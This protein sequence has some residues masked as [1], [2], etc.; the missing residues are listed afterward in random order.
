[1][2]FL[3]IKEMTLLISVIII[4]LIIVEA[5]L[6]P[7]SQFAIIPR[8]DVGEYESKS[9]EHFVIDNKIGWKMKENVSFSWTSSEWKS[10]NHANSQGFRSPE[11]ILN[12]ARKKIVLIGDS[13]GFGQFVNYEETFGAIIDKQNPGFVVY[14]L[15]MPG[16]GLDQMLLTL[17]YYGIDLKPD[18]V[19]ACFNDADFERSLTAYRYRPSERKAKPVFMLEKGKLRLKTI[20]DRTNWLIKIID[21]HSRIY[22]GFK[23]IMKYIGYN[24]PVGEW[25]HL[26]CAIIDKIDNIGNK[27]DFKVLFV[28]H[29]TRTWRSFPMLDKYMEKSNYDFINIRK[30][31][32]DNFYKLYYQ[33]D[34]HF[35]LF[36][37]K[38]VANE[39]QKYIDSLHW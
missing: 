21:R 27:N 1:M 35:N 8:Y 26:N 3:K 37:H 11:F 36:G 25:W 28:Y 10:I 7:F 14:N 33:T 20:K 2:K 15:A 30:A 12:D 29:P 31:P 23:L 9:G 34:P 4:C 17:Q 16:F 38:F 19:I 5:I 18:L 24:L 32:I 22:M 13:Y 6:I 39:I